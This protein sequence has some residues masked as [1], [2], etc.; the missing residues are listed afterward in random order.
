MSRRRTKEEK[1]LAKYQF[2]LKLSQD[3]ST[4][5]TNFV[6]TKLTGLTTATKQT[7]LSKK[8]SI[9]QEK[10]IDTDL[11]KKDIIKSLG[12]TSFI[13]TLELVLYFVFR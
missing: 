7:Q 12:L 10:I 5:Q 3:N 11:V 6:K 13:L 1:R 2:L 4:S 9:K 8:D